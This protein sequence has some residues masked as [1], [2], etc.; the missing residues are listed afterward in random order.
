[1]NAGSVTIPEGQNKPYVMVGLGTGMAPLRAMVQ[2]RYNYVKNQGG[3][4]N[5]P[6]ALFFG[7]RHKKTEFLYGD[8]MQHYI[9][10]GVLTNFYGAWSRDQKEKV[11]VHHLMKK[12]EELIYDYLVKQG[13]YY[14]LCGPNGPVAECREA[15]V[16]AF[17][18]VGKHSPEEADKMV[19][20]MQMTGRYNLDTW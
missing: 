9:D 6:M 17:V 2:D 15:L 19:T 7:N 14:Y 16:N 10:S 5:A 3:T 20:D 18:N 12:E 8:E 13:G 1:M 11:Y 4:D